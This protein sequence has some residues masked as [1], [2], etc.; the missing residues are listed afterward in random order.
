M[1]HGKGQF[2][3]KE[4]PVVKYRDSLTWAVHKRLNRSICRLGCGLGW[5]E[6]STS[7]II[8]ARWRQCAHMGKHIGASLN[9]LKHS[10]QVCFI[11]LV[12]KRVGWQVKLCDPS[13]KRAMPESYRDE[14]WQSARQIY[15]YTPG[16]YDWTVRLRRRCGLMSNYFDHLY[17]NVLQ[18]YYNLC[19]RSNNTETDKRF[20]I[21]NKS[22][23][24]TFQLT[25]PLYWE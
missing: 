7:S 11:P 22:C 12:N 2:W 21:A 5:A 10:L 13:L 1:P 18:R 16:E 19:L 14:S 4:L 20:W 8:F 3:G 9:T 23:K 25:R 15:G 6:G 17:R 24:N